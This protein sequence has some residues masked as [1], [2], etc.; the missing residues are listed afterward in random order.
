MKM[1]RMMA[2]LLATVMIIPT[3]QMEILAEGGG[4]EIAEKSVV[5]EIDSAEELSEISEDLDGKY[6]LT[7]D[8]DLSNVEY[9]PIGDKEHPFT[10][11]FDGDGHVISNL[12]IEGENIEDIQYLGLFGVLENAEVSNLAIENEIIQ[13]TVINI[14]QKQHWQHLLHI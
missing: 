11:T 8:I 3:N 13:I 7:S 6:V 4:N 2:L 12:S 1:K 5:T 14:V 10:G 9:E